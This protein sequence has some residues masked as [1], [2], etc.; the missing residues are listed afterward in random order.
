M[1]PRLGRLLHVDQ[2]TVTL[3]SLA[4]PISQDSE[5]LH[6]LV[7]SRFAAQGDETD[8]MMLDYNAL[9][10]ALYPAELTL[11]APLREKKVRVA[12]IV[13]VAPGTNEATTFH[14]VRFAAFTAR[15]PTGLSK[16]LPSRWW[17]N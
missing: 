17:P 2:L 5:A 16:C 1:H 4:L 6:L 7:G 10:K 13:G 15:H 8:R 12:G 3:G 14:E 11:S 9:V